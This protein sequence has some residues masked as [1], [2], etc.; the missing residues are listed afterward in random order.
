[1]VKYFTFDV[2]KIREDFPILSVLANGKLLVYL[3]NAATSQKPDSVIETLDRYYREYNS[4]IH[5]GVHYLSEIATREYEAAREK[6]KTH[7][8]AR[9]TGEIIF[10][11]G[12]TEGIN[13]VANSYGEFINEG[14]EILIT[15][16]EHHSN[17]VP[18]QMLCKRKKAKLK[19]IPV[20]EK[21]EIK[22]NDVKS[23][24]SEKTKFI[25]VVHISNTLGTINPVNEIIKFAHGKKIPVL[26]DAAQSV[27]HLKIDVQDSGADFVAF[28]GHKVYG[29][30]GIGVLYG[31]KEHLEKMPPYQGGGDMIKTVTFEKT[32]YNDLPYKFEAGTPNIANAIGLGAAFDYINSIGLVNISKYETELLD[33]ATNKLNEIKSVRIIGTSKNKAG[34]ISFLIDGVHPYD[35]GIILDKL[36]IAVRTGVHCTQPL[37]DKFRIPGT[38]RASFCFYNTSQEVDTLVKGIEK[39]IKML[40]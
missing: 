18:W 38:I 30:T 25:S 5:R 9:E 21:G 27:P 19:I 26:I 2:S 28:S 20:S 8:N 35:A 1:M 13:L 31:K 36:G 24:I 32:T 16:M 37:M 39:V 3:D 15:G 34:V 4:N 14:D 12:T 11:R 10:V 17:I 7:I 6:I 29:P 33:Y 23:L 22:L 40:K